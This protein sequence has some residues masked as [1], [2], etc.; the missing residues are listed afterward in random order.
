M[1]IQS[2]NHYI[3]QLSKL[4]KLSEF[5]NKLFKGLKRENIAINSSFI[6]QVLLR[7]KLQHSW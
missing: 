1:Y 2:L 4:Y 6:T 7:V 5:I 3:Y